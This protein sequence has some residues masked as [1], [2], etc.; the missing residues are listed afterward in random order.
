M[1]LPFDL[2]L[3]KPVLHAEPVSLRQ[4]LRSG[5]PWL[6]LADCV[7][8][9]IVTDDLALGLG[10]VLHASTD[11]SEALA[12]AVSCRENIC[13]AS[14]QGEERQHCDERLQPFSRFHLRLSPSL[15]PASARRW[16]AV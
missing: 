6:A 3:R 5:H 7:I 2:H 14:G 10:S 9:P 13:P 16:P 1:I 4:S 8:G 12:R 15:P 11:G